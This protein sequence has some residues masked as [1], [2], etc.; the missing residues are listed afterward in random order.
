MFVSGR[1]TIRGSRY[2]GSFSGG[3]PLSLS[4]PQGEEVRDLMNA[5]H[6]LSLAKDQRDASRLSTPVVER[7]LTEPSGSPWVLPEKGDAIRNKP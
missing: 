6:L 3:A 7:H 5:L 4:C 1:W 2:Q